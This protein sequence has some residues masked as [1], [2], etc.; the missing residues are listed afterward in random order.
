MDW[1]FGQ[2]MLFW[3]FVP[4][5]AT[6]FLQKQYYSFRSSKKPPTP[7]EAQFHYSV[8]YVLVVVVYLI[9]SFVQVERNLPPTYY[10]FL[11]VSRNC[12][13]RDLR[14]QFRQMS[15]LYHP[16]KLQSLP[17]SERVLHE[18]RY[19]QI[20]QAY[21]ILKEPIKR[22]AYDK[23]GLTSHDCQR[24]ATEREYL[25]KALPNFI[26]FYGGSAV[27]LVI[28][29]MLGTLNF[30]RYWR[31]VGLL[32]MG[33]F[34]AKILFSGPSSTALLVL[35]TLLPWRT[36]H[37]Q[38]IMLHQLFVVVF[39]AIS[40]LGPILFPEDKR[41][42]KQMMLELENLTNLQLKE[43]TRSFR[44]AFEP[45]A[46]DPVAVADV[47]KKMEKL[48]VDLQLLEGN[49]D[50]TVAAGKAQMRISKRK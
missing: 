25:M 35:R 33:C 42:V 37:E 21:D 38:I 39:I 36:L 4:S 47:Q 2:Q 29:S 18:T 16:D 3:T 40:Q 8:I 11:D 1:D 30:G 43:S 50:L 41:T 28:L 12:D 7:S 26:T 20:R 48:A 19:L 6:K 15:L 24:C 31:F 9:Y 10:D 5:M 14:S 13:A 22:A 46:R 23:Y 27:F 32:S 34:E 17:E 45:F 49:A 44:S